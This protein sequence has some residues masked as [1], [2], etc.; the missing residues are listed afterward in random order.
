M[1]RIWKGAG[2]MMSAIRRRLAS[3]LAIALFAGLIGRAQQPP[4]STPTV[5]QDS[6]T[7]AEDETTDLWF[8]ELASPPTADGTGLGQVRQ[9]KAAF[10]AAAAAARLQYTE[11]YAF[12]NLWNG[13]SVRISRSDIGALSRVAGVKAIYPV[14]T[15]T[16]SQVQSG[17]DPSSFTALKM[18]GADVVQSQLG[19]TGAGVRVAVIDTGIDYT[20]PD[21]GGCFGSGCR[22]EMGYDFVGDGYNGSNVPVPDPDP[23]DCNGHGTAVAGVVGAKAASAG[24]VTGV[25]PGVTL[26]A[27]RIFGC[28]GQSAEDVIIAAMERALADG[29]D[30]I[31]LS[32]GTVFSW[33]ESPTGR[34]TTR[35]VD[36]GI[37]VVAAMGNDAS[38][39]LYS[40]GAPAN[41][42][43]VIGVGSFD[44][45]EIRLRYFT[46]TPDTLPVGY[47]LSDGIQPPQSGSHPLQ[48]TGTAIAT[49]DACAALPPGSLN[50]F[51]ALIRSG[52]CTWYKQAINAQN[53]GAVG[54]VIYANIP[55]QFLGPSVA[56]TPPIVIPVVGITADEGATIDGRLATGPVTMTWTD[57]TLDSPEWTGGLASDFST[58]GLSPELDVKPDIGAPGGGVFTTVPV[59]LGS[60][61]SAWGTS[62]SSP[63][64]A[65][66]AA[67][68]L[69]AH[70][71][72]PSNAARSILQNAAEPAP[73]SGNPALGFL[74]AVQK[75]GAGLLHIDRAILATSA[76]EPGKLPLGESQGGPALR[77]LTISNKSNSDV[78]YDL[79][80]AP[81]L[82]TGPNTFSPT[83]FT[84][85][86]TVAFSTS[87][88][89]VPAGSQAS[90]DVT[91]TANPALP[92][93][94]L[95]GGYV[96][97]TA[98]GNGAVVRVPYAGFKGDYQSIRVLAPTPRGFPWLTKR[99]GNVLVNRPAG[100]AFTM[101]GTD[102][103]Y[104]VIHF[105]HQSRL[106]RITVEATNGKDWHRALQQEFLVRNTSAT[107]ASILPWDGTTSAGSKSY[108]V[109]NGDY[110]VTITVVKALG[111]ESNPADV[112]TWTSPIITIARP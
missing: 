52:T 1:R 44:N 51:V 90:V 80:H 107:G 23:M 3:G 99:S 32:L 14:G 27:Y 70:P 83:F 62:F 24:G 77:T 71:H 19:Y 85:F 108:V 4:T 15:V 25:A 98:R 29:T 111:D 105:D 75:Q 21:L 18:T 8:V 45:L 5:D 112:E 43:K 56:G 12:D 36:K 34:A 81:A 53:A 2:P 78:T 68:L 37:I 106:F 61:S 97:I 76:V 10:R 103:P 59:A 46:I 72:T 69:Q 88:L 74:D 39:G 7:A 87:T 11:R 79:S 63:H 109:P 54:V 93:H 86:A 20:H 26:H 42:V 47:E 41:G 100:A 9:E 101:Q 13:L 64:V 58:Y 95:Y 60:Y 89:T 91:I 17:I 38:L 66:A 92:D 96:V 102:I 84:G 82:S 57:K 94:S 30:V 50:G 55:H 35:L 28:T 40:S 110:R 48:R 65:G 22:V 73:W 6:V 33:A 16:H 104:F 31:N 49:A 67:L